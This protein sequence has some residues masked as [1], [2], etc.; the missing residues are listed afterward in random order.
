MKRVKAGTSRER[1]AERRALFIEAY[2]TNGGNATQAAISAGFTKKSAR[3]RG[4][5]LVKDRD[6]SKA[7]EERRAAV[8]AKA[9]TVTGLTVERTLQEVARLAYFDP[10]KL[11]DDKGNLKPVH[12]LDDDTAAAVGSVEQYEEYAGR[13]EEREIIGH[14]KKVKPFDKNAALDKAMKTLGLYEADNQQ[15]PPA[16]SLPG[17]RSVKFEPFKGRKAARNP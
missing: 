17:V 11:Y 16:V 3:S 8:L 13:G 1:A 10:R 12:E 6:L 9:Q 15:Q 14:T 4:F 2:L 5:E 7:I